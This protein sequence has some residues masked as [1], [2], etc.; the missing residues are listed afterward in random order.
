MNLEL[1]QTNYN[2]DPVVA[3]SKT[4]LPCPIGQLQIID[5]NGLSRELEEQKHEQ[6]LIENL[7]KMPENFNGDKPERIHVFDEAGEQ[8]DSAFYNKLLGITKTYSGNCTTNT[9]DMSFEIGEF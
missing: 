5:T 6:I 7:I 4:I 8:E 2:N 1:Q 3:E 9:R